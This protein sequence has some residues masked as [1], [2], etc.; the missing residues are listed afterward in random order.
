VSIRRFCTISVGY[1]C[2]PSIGKFLNLGRGLGVMV[3]VSGIDVEAK[4]IP[5][6]QLVLAWNELTT[7]PFP[8]VK[9]YQLADE[10][11]ERVIRPKRCI[12]DVEREWRSGA[13]VFRPWAPTRVF[14]TLKRLQ[15]PS[16][17]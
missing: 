3:N 17:Q 4:V 9:G 2:E 7:K 12:E 11:F 14:S 16:S 5:K 1:G 6:S 10:D 13:G 15:K 8:R